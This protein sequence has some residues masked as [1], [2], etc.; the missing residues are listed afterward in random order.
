MERPLSNAVPVQSTCRHSAQHNVRFLFSGKS[1]SQSF[2]LLPLLQ[3]PLVGRDGLTVEN[4]LA[5]IFDGWKVLNR[6]HF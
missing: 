3:S 6:L 4:R 2:S 1:G 5:T